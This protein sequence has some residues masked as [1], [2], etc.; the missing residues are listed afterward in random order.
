[1]NVT[2]QLILLLLESCQLVKVDISSFPILPQFL[3]WFVTTYHP[4][5]EKREVHHSKRLP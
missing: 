4:S 5:W 3:A 1:M 2:V